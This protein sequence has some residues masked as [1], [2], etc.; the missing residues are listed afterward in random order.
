[1]STVTYIT[2]D[3]ITAARRTDAPINRNVMGYGCKIPTCHMVQVDGKR[4]YRMYCICYSNSGST[5]IIVKG[6]TLY[7]GRVES[8][9]DELETRTN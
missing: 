2:E 5:Y 1:M 4:W 6:E 3:R 7:C 9:I 8:K